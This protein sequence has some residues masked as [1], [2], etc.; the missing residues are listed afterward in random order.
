MNVVISRQLGAEEAGLFFLVYTIVF[1][2]AV[3]G[4]LGLDNTFVR[5][6]ATHHSTNDWGR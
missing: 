3:I 2:A 4:R 5:F 6:I 1:I